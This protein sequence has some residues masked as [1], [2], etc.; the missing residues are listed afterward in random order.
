MSTASATLLKRQIQSCSPQRC[1][2]AVRSA[3]VH[4]SASR[5]PVGAMNRVFQTA[6]LNRYKSSSTQHENGNDWSGDSDNNSK[7]GWGKRRRR[8]QAPRIQ[9][10]SPD[11]NL[12]QMQQSQHSS[13]IYLS[14]TTSMHYPHSD[15]ASSFELTVEDFAIS[16]A[17]RGGGHV[18]LGKCGTGKSLLVNYLSHPDNNFSHDDDGDFK[19]LKSSQIAYVSFDSHLT[20]L[21]EHPNRTVHNVLTG[22]IGNLSKAAQYL[23]VRFGLFPLLT[24]TVST[25]ST[26]EIR[27]CL[28]VSALCQDPELL[29]LEN[30]FDGLDVNSR[31]ELQSI[32]SKTIQGLDK[33]G[34]LLIQQVQATSVR[35]VQV[36]MSTHRPEEIVDEIS[37]VSMTVRLDSDENRFKLITLDRPKDYTKE[38]LLYLAL[39]L[40]GDNNM[41]EDWSTVEPW[42]VEN[43]LLP[44]IDEIHSVWTKDNEETPDTLISLD[45]VEV[46][47]H[48]D[49]EFPVDDNDDGNNEFVT[50][51]HDM[52]WKVQKGQRWLIAGGNGA[53]KS[54]LTRFLLHDDEETNDTDQ[55]AADNYI[56][57]LISGG[58]YKNPATK[59]GWISTE[60]HLGMV[61]EQSL[62]STTS[63]QKSTWDV[64]TNDGSV[65][66]DMAETIAQWVF[67]KISA[68]E[69]IK[70]RPLRELSQGE[71]KLALITASLALRPNV[72]ILDEPTTGLDWISR[73][74]VLALLERLCQAT[75][76]D[77]A[78]IFITHYPEELVPSISHVLHLDHGYAV[79]QGT[80]ADYDRSDVPKVQ[81]KQ[82]KA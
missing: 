69:A 72:L 10:A 27:K 65:S 15:G 38:Q 12:D 75:P 4:S 20:T 24:R 71:Q 61:V 81:D 26:G 53:G 21:E 47:R 8:R 67:G 9:K 36:L 78:L 57:D 46:Q 45:H 1:A 31:K 3:S 41:S 16:K 35:P 39:G 5:R 59:I 70:N 33:S 80:K 51:L 6:A 52:S 29:I 18:L 79:Y 50:L 22:G 19:L 60:S 63:D 11:N 14:G 66:R 43:H 62:N 32:V 55:E 30:A 77:L 34:K 2:Q 56:H 37:T 42:E 64:I 49:G 23:V 76:D 82:K 68:I 74:R 13:L 40:N 44:S 17:R 25:L 73:R 48:R 7:I 28:L 58:Y 54:T